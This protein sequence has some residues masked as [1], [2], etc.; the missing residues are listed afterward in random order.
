M[1]LEVCW[2]GL[3]THSFG[4]SQPHGHGSWL[5]CEVTLRVNQLI[6]SPHL[7][8]LATNERSLPAW[9]TFRAILASESH[10]LQPMVVLSLVANTIRCGEGIISRRTTQI[11]WL[12]GGMWSKEI[13]NAPKWGRWASHACDVHMAMHGMAVGKLG[14]RACQT[15][16][17][18][19]SI[20]VSIY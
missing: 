11:T 8:V 3:W 12:I 10:R 5:M 2:D 19:D 15:P 20:N 18:Q 1:S 9:G 16:Y 6:P 13:I 7:L 17:S 14:L 4:L